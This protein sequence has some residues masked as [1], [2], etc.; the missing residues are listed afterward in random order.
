ML[1]LSGG[2]SR[3]QKLDPTKRGRKMSEILIPNEFK[4]RVERFTATLSSEQRNEFDALLTQLREAD[5]VAL[6][7]QFEAASELFALVD[8]TQ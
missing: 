2:R 6:R 4:S 8:M 5:Q 7:G 3:P 1:T